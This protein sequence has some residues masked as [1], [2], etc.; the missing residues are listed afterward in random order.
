[1]ELIFPKHHLFQ[2][3]FLN[4]VEKYSSFRISWNED[5]RVF[6]LFIAEYKYIVGISIDILNTI[7]LCLQNLKEIAINMSRYLYVVIASQW[8]H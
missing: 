4:I 8:K 5:W 2:Y 3:F 1:M 7:Y 6:T